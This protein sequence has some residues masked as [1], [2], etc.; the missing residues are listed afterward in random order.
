VSVADLG[1]TVLRVFDEGPLRERL[2]AQTA[3]AVD[4]V[5]RVSDDWLLA[6]SEDEL[7]AD[8]VERFDIQAPKLLPEHK[9]LSAGD[10]R[11]PL[12]LHIPFDGDAQWFRWEPNHRRSTGPPQ[13]EVRNDEVVITLGVAHQLQF[14]AGRLVEQWIAD[15]EY[16]LEWVE[17][18]IGV[19]RYRLP[20]EVRPLVRQRIQAVQTQQSVA[21]NLGIPIRRRDDAPRVFK[22]PSIKRR[23]SPRASGQAPGIDEPWLA[24]DYY[25]HILYVIRAAGKAMER[26]PETYDG[27]G[28]EDRRQMLVL[29]LNTHYAGEVYAEAF[30]KGGHTDILIRSA[31]KP[32]FI[33]ECKF[34]TGP[35]SVA[36]A[37]DQVFSYATWHDVKLALIL[38]IARRGFREAFE[39]AKE[40]VGSHDQFR[41][42]L[43]FEGEPEREFRAQ[44]AWPDDEL[45]R[46]TLHVSAFHT[47]APV[48]VSKDEEGPHR[49]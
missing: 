12:E 47:P 30:N 41:G 13:G 20:D 45:H 26:S 11:A 2:E 38:F 21:A 8:L 46:V 22:G 10:S 1:A 31:D 33:G 35:A 43:P 40:A 6:R 23:P 42:L 5:R 9:Q 39:K 37:I 3:L 44:M 17:H 16:Y 32:V 4:Y 24:E 15:V 25:D 29:M 34:Y 27:W 28:E 7:V 18:D 36:G 48:A 14:D 49:A 19:W